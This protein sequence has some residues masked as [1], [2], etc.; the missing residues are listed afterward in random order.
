MHEQVMSLIHNIESNWDELVS[1]E[2][3]GDLSMN[4]D[5]AIANFINANG[6]LDF[7]DY[8]AKNA[9]LDSSFSSQVTALFS[10]NSAFEMSESKID[11]GANIDLIVKD[12]NTYVKISDIELETS[13]DMIFDIS[14]YV[15]KLEAL[16]KDNT[17]LSFGSSTD[18]QALS[19]MFDTFSA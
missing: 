3:Y 19:F 14:A 18:T 9:F 16:A 7:R 10:S 15:D 6:S 11:L 8:N 12:G 2:E 5:L 13:E 4:F 17:Y 1:Y